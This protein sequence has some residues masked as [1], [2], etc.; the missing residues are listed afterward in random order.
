MSQEIKQHLETIKT[1]IDP[2]SR[3]QE[4][5]RWS[6]I[7]EQMKNFYPIWYKDYTSGGAATNAQTAYNHIVKILNSDQNP[8]DKQSQLVGDLV[9]KYQ[10]HQ[11]QMNQY[12]ALNLQGFM[13]QQNK[14]SWNEYLTKLSVDEPRLTTVINSVFMKLG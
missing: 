3:Q 2:F 7:V 6:G 8:K 10:D 11:Q 4:R 5:T 12:Q 14:D 1:A 13:V 9:K